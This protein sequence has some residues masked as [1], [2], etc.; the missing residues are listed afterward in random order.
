MCDGT[1]GTPNLLD[2]RFLEGFS[3]A[4]LFRKPGLPDITGSFQVDKGFGPNSEILNSFYSIKKSE[5]GGRGVEHDDT[6]E[7]NEVGFKASRNN[8]IYGA[9]NTVQPNSYTVYYII[10]IK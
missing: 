7:V 10:R 2:G 6:R 1:N 3:I 8:P 5:F 9:S 4:G